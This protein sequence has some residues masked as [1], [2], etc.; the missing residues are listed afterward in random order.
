MTEDRSPEQLDTAAIRAEVERALKAERLLLASVLEHLP[1]GVGVYD[2]EGT[3]THSNER[4]RDYAGTTL[5]PSR[6]PDTSRRWE[7]FDAQGHRI[8]PADY[9][10]ARALRGETVIPGVDYLY[11]P[12]DGPKQWTR[13]SAVPFRYDGDLADRA[14]VVVQDIDDLKRGA[15]QLQAAIAKAAR[16]S[17]FVEATLS[18]IPDFAYAFDTQRRFAYVNKAI[19][20][21]FGLSA[22][23]IIGKTLADLDYPVD[24]AAHLNGHI[25]DVLRDGVRIEDEVF[26]RSPTGYAAYFDYRWGPVFADDGS[27]ELVV[28][29]SRD[30]T[31]RRA[32]EDELERAAERLRAA[33]DLVGLGIYSWDPAT[34]ALDWDDRLRTMWGL[35]ADTPV[36]MAVYE[37]GIHPDDLPRVRAAIAAC[38]DPSGDGRYNV[39]Y[40]VIGRDDGITRHISTSGRTTFEQGRAIGFIGAAIDV[41]AQRRTE[42]AV[43]ESEAQFRSFADN[44][45]DLIWIVDP[46][47]NAIVYRSLAFERI[48]GIPREEG[49]VMMSDWITHVHPDDRQSTERA[50]AR[51]KAGEVVRYEYRILRPGDGAVRWLRDTGFPIT[52]EHGTITRIGGIAEDLTREEDRQVYIVSAGAAQARQLAGV[53][54]SL[55]HRA[56]VFES[57]AAFLDI[58]P[59]LSP[60]CVL[61]DLRKS[62]TEGLSIPRELT[63]RS[64]GLPAIIL[65]AADASVPSAVAAMKSGAVD[66]IRMS[67]EEPL[68]A[69][70]AETLSDCLGA[71]RPK[72]RDDNAAARVTRLTPREREVLVGLVDGGTNKSIAQTLGISPRTVEL[73]RA[74]VM[75]RLNAGGLTELIQIALSAGLGPSGTEGGK[76]GNIT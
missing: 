67:G 75:S 11:Q 30:T 69:A 25:D 18:S 73:H 8:A 58:A 21:L 62:R 68:R 48:W 61:V 13:V 36:D 65:D 54:R 4:M 28:G 26:F 57:V 38:A 55:G 70:L 49:P 64:I 34:S 3:L 63:A 19:L 45:D 29:V 37:A 9:A 15:E 7:R 43:R 51:V 23:E 5:L 35:P 46:A 40:R 72:T 2:P 56:R 39:E 44:S 16:Q 32:F 14:I 33:G 12:G 66:Y 41:T 71:M 52:D 10:G 24:L 50:I 42:A 53:I 59:V 6:E 22:D 27:V 60:G 17:R 74:Q 31:E 1:L 47:E 20:G 76:R